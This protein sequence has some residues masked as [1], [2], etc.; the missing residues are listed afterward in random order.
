MLQTELLQVELSLVWQAVLKPV[1]KANISRPWIKSS[2]R[3]L[4]LAKPSACNTNRS[5][6]SNSR[7]EV[8]VT[9]S[10]RKWCPMSPSHTRRSWNLKAQNAPACP[11]SMD[12]R[13][14]L[15]SLCNLNNSNSIKKISNQG[16]IWRV[17]MPKMSY[18]ERIVNILVQNNRRK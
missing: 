16:L 11:S 14:V 13:T 4:R 18:V 12:L 9:F 7:R 6:T 10:T 8:A 2:H 3:T 5:S 15:D 17:W 1:F